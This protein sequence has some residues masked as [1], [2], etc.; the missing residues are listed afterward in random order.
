MIGYA[1]PLA[2]PRGGL[3]HDAPG[4]FTPAAKILPTQSRASM[5]PPEPENCRPTCTYI[6]MIRRISALEGAKRCQ[7]DVK[8]SAV[9][10]TILPQFR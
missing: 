2:P 5:A 4:T 10:V 8:N 6:Y 1:G 3:T 9:L 7:P